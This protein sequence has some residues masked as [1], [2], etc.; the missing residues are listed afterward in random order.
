[1]SMSV[2]MEDRL[3]A[4]RKF[5][6]LAGWRSC[7]WFTWGAEDRAVDLMSYFQMAMNAVAEAYPD[8]VVPKTKVVSTL[9]G[10]DWGSLKPGQVEELA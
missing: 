9:S 1:M 3:S 4:G 5:A 8:W 7:S 6:S 10:R 2:S